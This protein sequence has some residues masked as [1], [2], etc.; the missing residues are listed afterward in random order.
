MVTEQTITNRVQ[1]IGN[2]QGK[3]CQIEHRANLLRQQWRK[4]DLAI[5]GGYHFGNLGDIALGSAVKRQADKLGKNSALQTIYNLP[6]WPK[7]PS[8]IVGGG[9]VAY[10]EPMRLL[11]QTYGDRP[12]KV[13]ILGVDFNE[14]DAI[15]ESREF[16]SQVALITCRSST[17]AASLRET[18]Q[19]E[20]V[21]WHY[22]LC[23]SYFDDPLFRAAEREPVFGLNTVAFFL[24]KDKNRFRPGSQFLKEVKEFSPDLIP[25][26][27]TLGE[28][29]GALTREVVKA[30][31]GAG[32]RVVHF[33]FTPADDVFART[34]LNDLNVTFRPYSPHVRAVVPAI[35]RCQRFF[36]T[37]FHSLIFSLVTRTPFVAFNYATKCERL[38]A[39]LDVPA[40]AQVTVRD[41]FEDP[42]QVAQKI[43]CGDTVDVAWARIEEN[44]A[45]VSEWIRRAIRQVTHESA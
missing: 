23:F 1:T 45:Q 16:L 4:P 32:F 38:L 2:L 18:L 40:S 43:V 26:L 36:T 35:G 42:A 37:R 9:A 11:R 44:G 41:L 7:S 8:L 29:Y 24:Q 30:A 3:M 15:R 28:R 17:Q 39:D 27:D 19:R 5:A 22:D 10:S 14:P 20:D 13:A 31:Q 25:H 6:Q 33:P 34:V 12:S 21:H